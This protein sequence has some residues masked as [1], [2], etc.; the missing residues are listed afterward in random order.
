M[1]RKKLSIAGIIR[2]LVLIAIMI[3]A[4]IVIDNAEILTTQVAVA[5]IGIA[6]LLV[7]MDFNSIIVVDK[8]EMYEL[9]IRIKGVERIYEIKREDLDKTLYLIGHT[10]GKFEVVGFD[11]LQLSTGR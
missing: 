2:L 3:L 5:L 10:E 11:R 4:M 6:F 7:I 9:I 1:M 8:P